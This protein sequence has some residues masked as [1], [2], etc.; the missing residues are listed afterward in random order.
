M[1]AASSL[2]FSSN[3]SEKETL[4]RRST[5]SNDQFDEQQDRWN[6]LARHLITDLKERSG[7]ALRSWLQGSYKFGTQIRPVRKGE[8]FDIDLGIYFQWEGRPVDGKHSPATL[9]S[10]IQD[11][12]LAYA[13]D[14]SEDVIE[15]CDPKPRCGR[16]RYQNNFHIDVPSY[17]LDDSKDARA[18]ATEEGWETSD[19][20]AIYLWFKDLFD[21]A[22]RAKVRRQVRYM[23][24]W[25]ALKFQDIKKRPS[26]ILLTV[27]VAEA[28]ESLGSE[29][30]GAD[31]ETLRD[32]IDSIID[33]LNNDQVV[34]T[35][36]H[37]SENLVRLSAAEMSAFQKELDILWDIAHRAAAA[38]SE[39][40]AADIW[41]EAFEYLFPL[42]EDTNT[43]LEKSRNLPVP[44]TMPQIKVT[45]KS[46]NN[47]FA[48]PFTDMN[49]IGPIPKN[50]D[51]EFEIINSPDLPRNSKIVWMVRNEG[52]E[53]EQVNDLG[54]V[55]REGL[56]A[57]ET[58]A[59]RGTH[60]MDCFV[61]LSG[62]T[63]AMRRVPVIITGQ[64]M[65]SRN[66]KKPSWTAL[67]GR[68]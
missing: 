58:S 26:S 49:R 28:A 34:L 43:I 57:S 2:F 17:H 56:K 41:Q 22:T 27:L 38:E 33:R 64:E 3:D 31:D 6:A 7:Y 55:K 4:H 5:P 12:L 32:I 29:N 10:F 20:K 16:I 9:K 51:I 15:V 62:Q 35:P 14:D 13:N 24:V 44:V 30:I 21:D 67:R 60:F 37:S 54:H 66:P 23:K 1:G 47:V 45:A 65:P 36:I 18:L 63:I 8:E 40:N 25:A 61:K 42:P 11:S 50:C 52:P 53:A 68:R 39:W 19:P 59:Y 46:R 48:K